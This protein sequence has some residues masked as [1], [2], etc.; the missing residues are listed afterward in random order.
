MVIGKQK[1]TPKKNS[2]N[3]LNIFS[4]F[5]MDIDAFYIHAYDMINNSTDIALF[6]SKLVKADE[7][8]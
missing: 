5:T 6:Y 8:H 4:I 3:L 2:K 7:G 1:K